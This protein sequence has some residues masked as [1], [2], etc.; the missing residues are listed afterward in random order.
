MESWKTVWR[1]GFAPGMSDAHLLALRAGL[2][3]DDPRITQGSTVTPPPVVI[4]QDMPAE[5]ACPLAFSGWQGDRLETVMQ[6]EEF[7]AKQ[8]YDAD[9]RC[10]EQAA[11]RYFINWFDDGARG[12]VFPALLAEVELEMTRR[13]GTPTKA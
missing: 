3:A 10:G 8:C 9:I 6:V 7:F 5:C 11:C 13:A 1:E 4:C 2:T 12:D